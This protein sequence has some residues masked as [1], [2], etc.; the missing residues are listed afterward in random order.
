MWKRKQGKAMQ[1]FL[2]F[3]FRFFKEKFGYDI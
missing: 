1:S 2:L 3:L